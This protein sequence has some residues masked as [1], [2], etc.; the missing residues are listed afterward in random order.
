MLNDT[1]VFGMLS[2]GKTVQCINEIAT[3]VRECLKKTNPDLFTVTRG[4]KLGEDVLKKTS[5]C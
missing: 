1:D 3:Y 5:R 4:P 2:K